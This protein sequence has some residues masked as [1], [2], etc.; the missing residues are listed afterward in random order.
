MHI[1]IGEDW[2]EAYGICLKS[3][4]DIGEEKQTNKNMIPN[5]KNRNIH[6]LLGVGWGRNRDC[7]LN[8]VRPIVLIYFR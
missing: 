5:V 3:S 8:K 6:K 7:N 1:R 4:A 2:L